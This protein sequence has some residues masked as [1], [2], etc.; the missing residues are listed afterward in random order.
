M[1]VVLAAVALAAAAGCT[2]PRPAGDSPLR[3]RD[4]VFSNATVTSN[5]QYGSA[6]DPQGNPVALTL[7]LYRPTGDAQ[8]KRPALVWVHGGA[9]RSGSKTDFVPVDVANTFA[10]LGYVVVSINYR[11]T[12]PNTCIANP[13]QPACTLAALDAQH[14]AQA[15]VRWLRKNAVTYGVDPARIG[16]GGES[17]GGIT[18]TLVGV[19]SEDTG[20]S[21]NPGYPSTVGGFVSVSGGLPDGL[22]AN[23]GDAWGLLFHGTVRR[24]S[25]RRQWS[26][27]TAG[28]LLEGRRAGLARSTRT[29]PATCPG[30]STARSIS[31]RRGYFLYFALDLPHAAGQP[32]GARPPRRSSRRS[33]C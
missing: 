30:R 32:A 1:L 7:D 6:P 14:D 20:T 5:L 17:A 3:Y 27:A 25:C 31:S 2:V 28:A 26:D 24:R 9:F 21:G 13:S 22:F 12:A 10:K 4:Q 11:L 19:H 16:V 8:T 18:A 33:A 29:A 23:A 15:A